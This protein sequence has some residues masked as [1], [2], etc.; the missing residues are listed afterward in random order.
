MFFPMSR[1]VAIERRFA[2]CV[3]SLPHVTYRL[4][5]TSKTAI[6]VKGRGPVI[7]GMTTLSF[8]HVVLSLIGI[9]AGFVVLFGMFSAKRLDGWTSLFW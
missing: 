9:F 5:S 6:S 2:P 1:Q 4:A 3:I 8:V 7:F